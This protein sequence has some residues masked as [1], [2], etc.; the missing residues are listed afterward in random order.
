MF[1]SVNDVNK[2]DIVPVARDLHALGYQ[3]IATWGTGEVIRRCGVPVQTVLKIHEGRPSVQDM[4]KNK[5]ISMIII[6]S[7][8]SENDLRDGKQLRRLAVALKVPIITTVAGAKA[9]AGALKALKKG[10]ISTLSLQDTFSPEFLEDI[11][12]RI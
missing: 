8:Q 11:R 7:D 12:Q 4:L 6:S 2:A 10:N 1:I 5:Q 9:T 3:I